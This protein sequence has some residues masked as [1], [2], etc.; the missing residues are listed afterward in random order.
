MDCTFIQYYT[1]PSPL[2]IEKR[3]YVKQFGHKLIDQS[4][5]IYQCT[6]VLERAANQ[7]SMSKALCHPTPSQLDEAMIYDKII[8]VDYVARKGVGKYTQWRESK[9]ERLREKREWLDQHITAQQEYTL[10]FQTS[11]Y[12]TEESQELMF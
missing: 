4:K 1:H 5:D 2:L 6:L 7:V 11:G 3:Y 9:A 8:G 12:L 10:T